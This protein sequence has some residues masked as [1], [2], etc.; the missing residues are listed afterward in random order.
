MSITK[1]QAA[2]QIEDFVK[3]YLPDLFVKN[4]AASYGDY[5]TSFNAYS[6]A[7]G[8]D[9]AYSWIFGQIMQAAS[10]ETKSPF[11]MSTIDYG[12]TPEKYIEQL[13]VDKLV[14]FLYPNASASDAQSAISLINNGELSPV[15]FTLGVSV[16]HAASST[17]T[18]SAITAGAAKAAITDNFTYLDIPTLTDS[19][20]NFLVSMYIGAFGRAP[21]YDGIMFW[22]GD[23][24][25]AI[26]ADAQSAFKVIGSNMYDAGARNN[27]GGTSLPNAD[28]INYAYNNVLGRNA[29]TDGYNFWLGELNS[30]KVVRG[31]FITTFIGGVTPG[32]RD[33]NFL[34]ARLKVG[35]FVA[36]ENISGHNAPAIDLHEALAGVVDSWTALSKVQS[37]SLQHESNVA[38]ITAVGVSTAPDATLL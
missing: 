9:A 20:Q 4:G 8:I 32:Q 12:A 7:K 1:E 17:L 18:L 23:L 5:I 2:V 13:P 28:Y 15:G 33:G 29:D 21:E 6:G 14:H 11:P 36:K 22:A 3:T 27:E 16:A 34:D 38:T 25:K 37:I 10:A 30:G 35:S 24:N 26:Q 19:Q 31:D